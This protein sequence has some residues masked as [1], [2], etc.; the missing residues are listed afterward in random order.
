V[1]YIVTILLYKGYRRPNTKLRG[2][3]I[4]KYRNREIKN[5]ERERK[6]G[7]EKEIKTVLNT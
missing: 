1:V 7:K 6:S 3:E 5:R 4:K 2:E